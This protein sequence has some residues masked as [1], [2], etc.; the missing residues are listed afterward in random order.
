MLLSKHPIGVSVGIP[1]ASMVRRAIA[2]PG[3]NLIHRKFVVVVGQ[4]V[5]I[6]YWVMME[7]L[8]QYTIFSLGIATR[9]VK[10]EFCHIILVTFM[11][12]IKDQFV[13]RLVRAFDMLEFNMDFNAFVETDYPIVTCI[14]RMNV[15]LNVREMKLKFVVTVGE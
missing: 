4:I 13:S 11:K 7:I 15:I 14:D 12:E 1:M 6:K 9:I 5:C 3:V 10:V 8:N 2:I